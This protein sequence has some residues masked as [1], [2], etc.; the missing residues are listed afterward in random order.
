MIEL[1][2]TN[3]LAVSIP[4]LLEHAIDALTAKESV[5]T[6]AAAILLTGVALVL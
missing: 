1:L 6:W 3:G 2:A 4:A 5:V